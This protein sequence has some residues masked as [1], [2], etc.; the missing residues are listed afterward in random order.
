MSGNFS[1]LFTLNKRFIA[2]IILNIIIFFLI[3]VMASALTIGSGR[4]GALLGNL[5]F[6]Y[7]IDFDC[8]VPILLC[9]MVLY[10][11]YCYNL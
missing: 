11:E 5:A 10:G 7:L 6:G 2:I 9:A 4:L 1:F 3:R 8:I